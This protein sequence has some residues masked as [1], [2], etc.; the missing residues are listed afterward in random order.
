MTCTIPTEGLANLQRRLAREREF[1]GGTS[2]YIAGILEAVRWLMGPDAAQ[3]AEA[4]AVAAGEQGDETSPPSAERS[5]RATSEVTGEWLSGTVKWFN[6][7]RNY[8]FI[9]CP[10]LGDVFVHGMDAC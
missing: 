8:G 5:G 9:E 7:M 1:F 10:Q 4:T 6:E 2:D 3:R